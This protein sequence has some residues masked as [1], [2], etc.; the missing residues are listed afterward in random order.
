MAFHM[1]RPWP[2]VPFYQLSLKNCELK[3]T[4]NTFR[5]CSVHFLFYWLKDYIFPTV[6]SALPFLSY[7]FTYCWLDPLLGFGPCFKNWTFSYKLSRTEGNL[8][9]KIGLALYLL[10]IWGKFSKY[11]PPGGRD[12]YPGMGTPRNSSWVCAARFFKLWP[13]FRPKNVISTS[14]FRPGL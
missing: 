12:L 7:I 13:D 5:D 4:H 11:K 6:K 9:F 14:V 1:S 8:S 3:P 2:L 10:C